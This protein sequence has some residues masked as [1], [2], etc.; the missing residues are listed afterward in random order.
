MMTLSQRK[1]KLP[2]H[3]MRFVVNLS[4]PQTTIPITSP[5][6]VGWKFQFYRLLFNPIGKRLNVFQSYEFIHS[7]VFPNMLIHCG[8][9]RFISMNTTRKIS[10]QVYIDD[11]Q[12]EWVRKLIENYRSL[13]DV[14]SN[15]HSSR[16]ST[17]SFGT[18]KNVLFMR[19]RIGPLEQHPCEKIL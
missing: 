18:K 12:G 11:W 10:W 13:Y 7:I 14:L 8:F 15:F 5:L 1:D 6:I 19:Q 2:T 4:A 17:N 3:S 16:L 9:T